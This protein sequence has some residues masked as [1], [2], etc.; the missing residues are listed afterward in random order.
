MIVIL[1]FYL[2]FWDHCKW[3][4]GFLITCGF[5]IFIALIK[6]WPWATI[7]VLVCQLIISFN[8]GFKFSVWAIWIYIVIIWLEGT[9]REVIKLYSN[10][11]DDK[12]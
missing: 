6:S 7:F 9:A 3:Y 12:V 5:G 2:V 8:E 11:K 4:E 10:K 1:S